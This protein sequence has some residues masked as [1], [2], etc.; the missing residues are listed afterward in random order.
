MAASY[1]DQLKEQR[2]YEEAAVMYVKATNWENAL[3]CFQTSHNA[4][5]VMC[6]AQRLNYT[7]EKLANL[8]SSLAGKASFFFFY[9]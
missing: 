6:M 4:K 9:Y 3:Q 2:F 7:P 8:A 5:Q 1:A